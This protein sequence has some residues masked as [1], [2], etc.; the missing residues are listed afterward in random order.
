MVL[1]TEPS[2]PAVAD[3]P[4]PLDAGAYWLPL[5]PML[6]PPPPPAESVLLSA[7]PIPAPEPSPPV[8][9]GIVL[10]L[11]PPAPPAPPEPLLPLTPTALP[12]RDKRLSKRC[13]ERGV[14]ASVPAIRDY[15]R[16]DPTTPAEVS[17]LQQNQNLQSV[18]PGRF[19]IA[20]SVPSTSVTQ[21]STPGCCLYGVT[22][23]HFSSAF[24]PN[25][26]LSP[27]AV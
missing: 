1:T 9:P 4:P 10:P 23:F 20:T 12:Q 15:E 26:G 22:A 8:P 7:P 3:E 18:A 25:Q 2:L 21:W 19:D 5:G 24:R 14:A 13:R 17:R 11:S 16:D 6:P 27:L